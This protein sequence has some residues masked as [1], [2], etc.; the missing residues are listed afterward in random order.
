[1]RACVMPRR[2]DLVKDIGPLMVLCL[3]YHRLK[4]GGKLFKSGRSTGLEPATF[5]ITI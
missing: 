1:M 4:L 5:R 3:P 2:T